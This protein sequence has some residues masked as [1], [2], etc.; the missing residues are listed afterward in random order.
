VLIGESHLFL[1][2]NGGE[3]H[4][5]L[6]HGCEESNTVVEISYDEVSV[7][8]STARLT[9]FSD[10]TTINPRSFLLFQHQWRTLF[11]CS[12][13]LTGELYHVGLNF[14]TRLYASEALP[15]RGGFGYTVGLRHLGLSIGSPMASG[16]A[17]RAASGNPANKGAGS[18][19]VHA[20][21]LRAN[22]PIR[23][24]HR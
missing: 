1:P 14:S 24:R 10:S 7:P 3:Q 12:D 19:G 20:Y 18:P 17:C 9:Q 5:T 21:S 6:D 23:Q 22:R 15:E 11:R 16:L 8:F 4:T 13:V 2:K